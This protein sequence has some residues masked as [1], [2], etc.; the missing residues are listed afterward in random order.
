MTIGADS[1]LHRIVEAID[2]IQSTAASHQR[3]FVVEVMGRH[4]GYL[5][6]MSAIAGGADYV[7][8]PEN[9]PDP[10]WE[11][12]MCEL[13]RQ[14][15]AAG[16]RNSIVIV[17]EGAH[18]SDNKPDHAASTCARCWRTSSARTPG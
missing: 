15:R 4:C 3:S 9:P 8:I 10:G 17:A 2:S 7:F 14:G 16:R 12:Q 11:E 5:A 18:D 13:L 6:L 1:A